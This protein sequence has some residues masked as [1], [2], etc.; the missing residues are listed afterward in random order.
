[1][2]YDKA[3]FYCNQ[4]MQNKKLNQAQLNEDTISG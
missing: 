4:N 2:I 3:I 1:M